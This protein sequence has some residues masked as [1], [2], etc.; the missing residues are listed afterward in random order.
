MSADDAQQP[1][2]VVDN[3]HLIWN[4]GAYKFGYVEPFRIRLS[5]IGAWELSMPDWTV[6]RVTSNKDRG[7]YGI[8]GDHMR[9][10]DEAMGLKHG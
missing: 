5:E 9:F 4:G 2:L 7:S 10:I 3:G 1:A 8:P 6:V